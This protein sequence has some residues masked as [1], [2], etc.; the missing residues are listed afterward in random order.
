[1]RAGH[2]TTFALAAAATLSAA[3]AGETS[4][5]RSRAEFERSYALL[6]RG[7]LTGC[8][9]RTDAGTRETR[10][11]LADAASGLVLELR[12]R[13]GAIAAAVVELSARGHGTAVAFVEALGRVEDSLG[14]APGVPDVPPEA[15]RELGLASSDEDAAPETRRAS[16][17]N[18][19]IV[20]S[21]SRRPT[22]WVVRCVLTPPDVVGRE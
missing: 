1:M 20:C 7:A 18:A 19:D 21:G 4:F 13:D 17:P 12:G 22:D 8:S 9:E 16:T 2:W 10:C 3:A 5:P 14:T 6:G 11:P 15:L